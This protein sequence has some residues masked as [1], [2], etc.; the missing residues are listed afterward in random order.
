MA[1]TP[2]NAV[3]L[4]QEQLVKTV[5]EK[6]RYKV[7]LANFWPVRGVIGGTLRYART[8]QL[9]AGDINALAT[10]LADGAD[11]TDQTAGVDETV[12]YTCGE[13]ASR[14]K[15]D[16][17]AQDRWRY[18]SIDNALAII[19]CTRLLLMSFRKLDLDNASGE[20]DYDS[21]YDMCDGS[22]IVAGGGVAPT[23]DKLQ[24]TW[25]LVTA[26]NA[27]ANCI[28]CNNRASRAIIKAYNDQGMHPTEVELPFPDPISGGMKMTRVPAING[29]PILVN[30][31]IATSDPGNTTRIYMMVMGEDCERQIYGVTGI[32][33]KD[34][35]GKLF[36]RRE[37]AEPSAATSSRMNVT[38]TYPTATAMGC[39]SALA[40]LENV[41]V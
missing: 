19:A 8:N 2:A 40:I 38:Y 37:S 11:I 41:L 35:E 21:L 12:T 39:A 32:I 20:G 14:Y 31:L 33:P 23:L 25:H 24:Q 4:T 28:M 1:S 29:T 7:E 16:Y 5:I 26:G 17:N 36:I 30:D 34:L 18:Q 22:Q 15:L 3:Q 27:R 10:I 9:S 6:I 13:L